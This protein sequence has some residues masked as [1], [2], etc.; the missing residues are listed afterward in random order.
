LF[1]T[2]P[3][4]EQESIESRDQ[5]R[6]SRCKLFEFGKVCLLVLEDP[7]NEMILFSFFFWVLPLFFL[8]RGFWF[9]P[10]VDS[11]LL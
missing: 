11:L 1:L 9:T 5:Y 10:F 7:L 4:N 6:E 8:D 3:L 2:F